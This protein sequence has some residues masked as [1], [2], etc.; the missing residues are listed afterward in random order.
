M[1]S[2]A[3]RNDLGSPLLSSSAV[4]NFSGIEAAVLMGQD[5][6]APFSVMTL[7]VSERMGSPAHISPDED[8]LF[9]VT[10]G[11]FVFLV[12]ESKFIAS[13]GDYVFVGKGEVHSFSAKSSENAVM[14]LVSSP[15]GHEQFFLGLAE[16]PLPHDEKQVS[17]V[18]HR[19]RQQIVGPV[20]EV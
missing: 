9:H 3:H 12:G 20:V 6:G 15:A 7:T 14:T 19:C 2:Q 10:K 18:C 16:L 11:R 5:D 1:K 4:V 8:K 17:E 13:S